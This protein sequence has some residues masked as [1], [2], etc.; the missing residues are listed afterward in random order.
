MKGQC[1]GGLKLF[2]LLH[3]T[4]EETKARSDMLKLHMTA[5][6]A[7]MAGSNIQEYVSGISSLHKRYLVDI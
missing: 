5:F 1:S 2:I 3:I 7:A 6:A 4:H